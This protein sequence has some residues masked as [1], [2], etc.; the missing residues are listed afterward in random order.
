MKKGGIGIGVIIVI[1][2]ATLIFGGDPTSIFKGGSPLLNDAS[3]E[4]S[5]TPTTEDEE[6]ARF[7]RQILAS[8]E[9]VWSQEFAKMG[10][11]YRAPTLVLFTGAVESACGQATA[12]GDFAYA[13]V[14]AHEVGHHVQ[15]LLGILDA[16]HS[17]M[18]QSSKSEANK[19]SVRI[20]LQADF[21][22]GVWGYHE[23][24]L[25]NSLDDG[26][27]EEAVNAASKIGDDILQQQG[28]GYVVPDAFT[29]GRADQR[30][31]WL[32]RG[33]TTGDL[34]YGDTFSPRYDQL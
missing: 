17:Q 30:M 24:R 7:S 27:I 15:H 26:D 33:L 14:I 13:Y 18:A 21:L 4:S 5:Y 19:T 32:K 25:F 2:I 9:D 12:A 31:K 1:A 28:Q 6:L 16:G 23:N 8:T 3:T 20:E 11:T 34:D 10:K 22:A 29:H